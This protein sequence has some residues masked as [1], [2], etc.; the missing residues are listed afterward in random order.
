MQPEIEPKTQS[1]NSPSGRR[2]LLESAALQRP[3]PLARLDERLGRSPGRSPL[4]DLFEQFLREQIANPNVPPP[5]CSALLP[6]RGGV[7]RRK[8]ARTRRPN[9]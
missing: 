4:P 9:D 5:S 7:K 6:S 2:Y 3:H 8:R 1:A